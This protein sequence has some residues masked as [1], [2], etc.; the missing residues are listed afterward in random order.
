M[1]EVMERPEETDSQTS[2]QALDLV[3]R[4]HHDYLSVRP[5]RQSPSQ[6]AALAALARPWRQESNARKRGCGLNR[7]QSSFVRAELS[8]LIRMKYVCPFARR[9]SHENPKADQVLGDQH[10]SMVALLLYQQ[11]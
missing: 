6:V 5:H 9:W 3:R 4:M 1:Q 10:Y 2:G 7:L 8:N 11:S